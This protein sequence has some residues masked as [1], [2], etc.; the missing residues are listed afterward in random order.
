MQ[1]SLV[2]GSILITLWE[3]QTDFLAIRKNR[4]RRE[5]EGLE[6]KE[7]NLGGVIER[8]GG[9]IS[10]TYIVLNSQGINKN[11]FLQQNTVVV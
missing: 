6:R 1:N 11:V 9:Q 4:G 2:C 10:S 7:I 3:A 8:S 5:V